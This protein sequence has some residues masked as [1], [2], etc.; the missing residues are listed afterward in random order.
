M[1]NSQVF[2]D[3]DR[4]KDLIINEGENALVVDDNIYLDKN[5]RFYNDVYEQIIPNEPVMHCPNS[6]QEI[7]VT[8]YWKEKIIDG[9]MNDMNINYEEIL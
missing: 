1:C 7:D 9:L 6:I 4:L 3:N 8:Y 2:T 5:Y